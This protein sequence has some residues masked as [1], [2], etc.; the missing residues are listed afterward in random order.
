VTDFNVL[1]LPYYDMIVGIDW[2]E[3]RSPL[4]IDWLKRWMVFN[5]GGTDVHLHGFQPAVLAHSMVEVP[6]VSQVSVMP[7]H[8]YSM[9]A[10]I[11]EPIQQLLKSFDHLF[12]EPEGLS[13]SRSCD[14]SIPLVAGAQQV[15]VRSYGFSPAM[16]DKIEK[17]I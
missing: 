9:L 16:K 14:H 11:P 12:Q 15:N 17:Q 2:L 3:S 4:Q 1:P 10:T 13:P 6:R 5:Q 8:L 7:G